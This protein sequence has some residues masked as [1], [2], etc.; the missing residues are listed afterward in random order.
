M[1][2]R[3]LLFMGERGMKKP[4][5]PWGDRGVR[6]DMVLVGALAKYESVCAGHPARVSCEHG[7]VK[8]VRRRS[9][10]VD[11]LADVRDQSQTAPWAADPTSRVYFAST[12]ST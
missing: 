2:L 8:Q 11:T 7:R 10:D 9:Q 3:V 4:L 6:V 1:F 12:P 5:G